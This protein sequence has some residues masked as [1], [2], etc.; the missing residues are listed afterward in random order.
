MSGVT[1]LTVLVADGHPPTRTGIK[2][3]LEPHGLTVVAEASSAEEAVRMSLAERPNICVLAV[4]LRGN[5]IEAARLIK[6]ALP[7]TKIVM[8]TLAPRDEEFLEAL[9]AGADGYLLMNTSVSRLPY[10]LHAVSRGE[11]ALPRDMT[12]RLITEFR[13]RGARRRI[14]LPSVQAPVELTARE[15]EVLERLRRR[16]GTAD[17][18]A[19]L[20]ISQVTVRRHVASLL[21]KLQAPN[22]R[23]AVEMLDQADETE[24]RELT[25]E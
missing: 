3:A 17:I 19:H 22:R 21:R 15:F 14:V 20:G 7:E 12:S 11:P 2:R 1:Q 23:R 9:R 16:E 10:V 4:E 13:Q 24:Q 6:E 8:M 18:A 5:G 25:T